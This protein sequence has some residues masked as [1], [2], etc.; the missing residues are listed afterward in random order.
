MAVTDD[1][2]REDIILM[3]WLARCH[4]CLSKPRFAWDI[5]LSMESS[6]HAFDLLRL[7]GNECYAAGQFL[8]AARAF[9]ILERF[10]SAPENWEGKRGACAGLFQQVIAG[11]ESSECLPEVLSMLS[12][13]NNQQSEF[14]SNVM[15]NWQEENGL[16]HE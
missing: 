4:I 7:I 11:E 1:K 5:Y 6:D 15:R 3:T 14:M 9:D 16:L 13:S 10:D 2:Y 12:S 8:Y